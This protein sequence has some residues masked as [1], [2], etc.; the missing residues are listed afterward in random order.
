MPKRKNEIEG[1]EMPQRKTRPRKTKPENEH[2]RKA[3]DDQKKESTVI[4]TPDIPPAIAETKK[5]G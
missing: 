5:L 2:Y 4:P 1:I 3:V